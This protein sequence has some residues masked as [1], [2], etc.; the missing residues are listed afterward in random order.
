MTAPPSP[1]AGAEAVAVGSVRLSPTT[2]IRTAGQTILADYRP[3]T[4]P[5]LVSAIG[6]PTTLGPRFRA[7]GAGVIGALQAEGAGVRVDRR[8]GLHLA[9]AA[10]NDPRAARPLPTESFATVSPP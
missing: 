5:Y 9:A 8:T 6:D 7:A 2:A 10:G 4:A 1:Y 3:L